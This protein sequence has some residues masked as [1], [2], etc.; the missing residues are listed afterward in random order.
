[1]YAETSKTT[2][3]WPQQHAR[4]LK[5]AAEGMYKVPQDSFLHSQPHHQDQAQQPFSGA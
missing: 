1:M 4:S 2:T 5:E 3:D